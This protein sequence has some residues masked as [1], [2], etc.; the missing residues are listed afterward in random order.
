MNRRELREH[1]FMILF[2]IE[3]SPRDEFEEQV[4]MYLEALKT[5]DEKGLKYIYNQVNGVVTNL[6]DIDNEI[7]EKTENWKVSRMAKV[8]LTILRLAIYEINYDN[9][10]PTNVSINEAVELAKKFGGDQSSSF[11]N[12]I[13][14]K[15]VN[16]ES[17]NNQDDSIN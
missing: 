1:T 17:A 13:L 5:E 2:R 7:D 11:I 10:I 14:A 8:D 12:G 9:E 15:I 3:F 4:K 6:V 16:K